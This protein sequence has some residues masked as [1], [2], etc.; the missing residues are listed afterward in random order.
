MST[1]DRAPESQRDL[2]LDDISSYPIVS[3]RIS[4]EDRRAINLLAD[5]IARILSHK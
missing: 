1:P 5:L 2:R 4:R 3:D